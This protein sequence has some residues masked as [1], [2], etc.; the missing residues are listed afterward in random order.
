MRRATTIMEKGTWDR[1][2]DLASVRLT[3]HDRYRRRIVLTDSTG[4]P[5]RLDLAQ[6]ALLN[7]GDGLLLDD[8][9]V[10]AV[11]AAAEDVADIR[12]VGA[13]AMARLAWHIGN[14]HVALQILPDGGLR[15]HY[16]PVLVEMI[17]GLGG[18]ITRLNAPFSPEKGAYS[19][20]RAAQDHGHGHGH[21]HDHS[22]PH[23]HGDDHHD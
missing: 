5:F 1:C 14:R 21:D 11:E 3:Y 10:I 20:G 18:A 23:A 6:P 7:D 2:G 22:H 8:G 9:G 16:D 19:R 13:N 17:R 4:E 15:I 12:A